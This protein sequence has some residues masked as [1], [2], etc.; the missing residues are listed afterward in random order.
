MQ[1]C[2]VFVSL[3]KT[4][5]GALILL[6]HKAKIILVKIN[7]AF[8]FKILQTR[9]KARILS[10]LV[11]GG[12]KSHLFLECNFST[13]RPEYLFD[14]FCGKDISRTLFAYFWRTQNTIRYEYYLDKSSSGK[15]HCSYHSKSAT[16]TYN[17]YKQCK[18]SVAICFYVVC[19][20]LFV[21]GR[22]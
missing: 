6:S 18:S 10:F 22:V 16:I 20:V 14:V 15:L 13:I 9:K 19:S 12:V 5:I 7:Y 21:A 4:G 11:K 2:L 1:C 3:Q 17:V 8:K